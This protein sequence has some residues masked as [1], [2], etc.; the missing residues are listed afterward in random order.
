MNTTINYKKESSQ[1][2]RSLVVVYYRGSPICLREG[3]DPPLLIRI[4]HY[5]RVETGPS[6]RM[7]EKPRRRPWGT[8]PSSPNRSPAGSLRGSP[9]IPGHRGGNAA[10]MGFGPGWECW[11]KAGSITQMLHGTAI[12]AD[13][14]GCCQGVNVCIYI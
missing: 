5:Q 10:V 11:L 4:Q 2:P 12:Y 7:A 1:E 3:G 14:L 9:V 6:K 13:Q 8:A